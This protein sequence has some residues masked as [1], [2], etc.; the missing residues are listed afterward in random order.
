MPATF[1]LILTFSRLEKEQ[2]L[3]DFKN[4]WGF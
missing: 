3:M 1:P 4:S 2:P